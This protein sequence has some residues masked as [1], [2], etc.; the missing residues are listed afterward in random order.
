MGMAVH[1][2]FYV[3]SAA[4]GITD[5]QIDQILNKSHEYNPKHQITGVLLFRGGI[6]LQLLEGAQA[7]VEALFAKI[8][9]DTRHA[10]IISLFGVSNN[11]RIY[12]DWSMAY[13]KLEDIDI[14]FVNEILS[15]N[16]LINASREL[17]NHLILHMLSRFK[18]RV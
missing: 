12:S 17:D 11:E 16:K 15:W 1:Q 9:K 18:S 8:K 3:S 14:K 6:F 7:D 2:L 10:N 13:R 5:Q 4:A